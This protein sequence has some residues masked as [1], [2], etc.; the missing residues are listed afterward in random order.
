MEMGQ[1]GFKAS[2]LPGKPPLQQGQEDLIPDRPSCDR[3]RQYPA[4]AYPRTVV[5]RRPTD[6]CQG[7]FPI[8]EEGLK[9][10]RRLPG[11]PERKE[12]LCLGPG[13]PFREKIGFSSLPTR[14]PYAVEY[15]MGG[16]C[17]SFFGGDL[18]DGEESVGRIDASF[19]QLGKDRR[20]LGKPPGQPQRRPIGIQHQRGPCSVT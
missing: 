5:D 4:V 3:L 11:A 15:V 8:A 16:F 6:L 2:I 14:L 12:E 10:G 20:G 13:S 19:G 9:K 17:A 1:C 7:I 18:S